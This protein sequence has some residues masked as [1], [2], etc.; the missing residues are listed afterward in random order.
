MPVLPHTSSC[1][2]GCGIHRSSCPGQPRFAQRLAVISVAPPCQQLSPLPSPRPVA[3]FRMCPCSS[4]V[5][6]VSAYRFFLVLP[7]AF[8]DWAL[9]AWLESQP[10]AALLSERQLPVL[11]E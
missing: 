10:S 11:V 9:Q 2:S 1:H 3:E 6:A 5:P 8:Q 7:I 4:L